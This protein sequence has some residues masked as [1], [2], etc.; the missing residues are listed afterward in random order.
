MKEQQR[1]NEF[2][3]I[4]KWCTVNTYTHTRTDL[5]MSII[6]WGYQN[7]QNFRFKM[8]QRD[9]NTSIDMFLMSDRFSLSRLTHVWNTA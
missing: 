9:G 5:D 3:S 7:T 8:V 1:N 6:T 2:V 4:P